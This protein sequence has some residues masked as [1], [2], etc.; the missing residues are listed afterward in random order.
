MSNSQSHIG[1]IANKK[2]A[3][4]KG[5]LYVKSWE[6][7][8][9][10]ELAKLQLLQSSSLNLAEEDEES[11]TKVKSSKVNRSKS[12]YV[13]KMDRLM[14]GNVYLVQSVR[15]VPT[16]DVISFYHL[17]QRFSNSEPQNFFL[18]FEAF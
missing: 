13:A 10:L 18:A 6:R 16:C 9:R 15:N 7:I 8:Q 4:N 11:E 5:R 2:T 14:N 1:K 3:Y 17:E 12:K